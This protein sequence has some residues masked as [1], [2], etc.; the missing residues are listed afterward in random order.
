L[1]QCIF[2]SLVVLF[3]AA[4]SSGPDKKVSKAEIAEPVLLSEDDFATKV[5]NYRT[6]KQW[7]YIGDKPCIIDFYAVWCGPCR[8][9]APIIQDIAAEYADK[10]YVYKVNTDN[11]RELCTYFGID[12]IPAVMFCPMKGDYI[13]IV[14][15]QP[16]SKYVS[17]IE[18]TLQ[19]KK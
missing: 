11:A 8:A 12:G 13:F 9:I 5:F 2:I 15:G 18:S 10:L 16:K 3:F 7:N 1:K 4:C 6:E 14:G 19:V 17:L